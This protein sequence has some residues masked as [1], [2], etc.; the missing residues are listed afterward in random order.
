MLSSLQRWPALTQPIQPLLQRGSR[1]LAHAAADELALRVKKQGQR[2]AACA[3]LA[4]QLCEVAPEN[5]RS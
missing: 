4:V 3:I 2:Q 5:G 1:Q